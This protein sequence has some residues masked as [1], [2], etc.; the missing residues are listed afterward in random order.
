M[1]F[2]IKSETLSIFLYFEIKNNI[3]FVFFGEKMDK[4]G[5]IL[6]VDDEKEIRDLIY[7][8]LTKINYLVVTAQDG[9]EALNKYMQGEFDLIISDLVMPNI[10]G[11]ELLK[12]IRSL[13]EKIMFLMITGHPTIDTAVEAIKEGAYDYIT[14]PFSMED[15][16]IRI[17]HALE[18]KYLK[19]RIRTV[20]G[21]NWAL[22]FSIPIWLILGIILAILLR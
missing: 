22:L 2:N 10:D 1:L 15:L 18:R 17:E 4:L 3:I 11:L 12:R 5:H 20:M 21:F 16:K 13:D 9:Q 8:Y 6:V 14:K 7:N 19:G